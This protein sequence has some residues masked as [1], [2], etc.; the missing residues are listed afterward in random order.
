MSKSLRGR[1]IAIGVADTSFRDALRRTLEREGAMVAA[2][3]AAET[4]LSTLPSFSPDVC[5]LDVDLPDLGPAELVARVRQRAA[6]PIVLVS[7]HLFP[8]DKDSLKDLPTLPLPFSRRQLL[9]VLEQ[10]TGGKAA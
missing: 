8:S 6:T 4:L 5:I 1:K 10:A 2:S 3:D 7:A 9:E